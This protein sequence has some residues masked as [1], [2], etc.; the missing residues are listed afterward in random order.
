MNIW[1]SVC[2]K[3]AK[4]HY[5]PEPINSGEYMVV[6]GFRRGKWYL[7]HSWHP[8]CWIDQAIV[9]LE[10]RG[11]M[12]ETRGRKKMNVPDEVRSAR[13]KIIARRASVIQRLK[14]AMVKGDLERIEHLAGE[15]EKLK[16]EIEPLGGVPESW[17]SAQPT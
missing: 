12:E 9:E 13:F 4:C 17:K 7:R 11:P 3:R 16:A 15:L 14:R 5:C 8:Q 6:A 10:R 1:M 2:K